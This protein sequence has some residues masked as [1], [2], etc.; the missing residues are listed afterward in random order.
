ML[1]RKLLQ[2][3]AS[4]Q[5]AAQKHAAEASTSCRGSKHQALLPCESG[6]LEV[7]I[8]VEEIEP[9]ILK[10]DE[11][12]LMQICRNCHGTMSADH[13]C[14]DSKS[15]VSVVEEKPPPIP[16]CVCDDWPRT[17]WCSCSDAQLE[18]TKLV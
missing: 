2:K 14:A 3:A 13:Q 15:P 8:A 18:H 7:V 6:A 16:L 9:V 12:S 4:E 5:E 10:V 1:P 17:C 11:G